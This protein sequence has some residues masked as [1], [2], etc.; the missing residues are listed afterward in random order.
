MP[1]LR[2]DESLSGWV[3]QLVDLYCGSDRRF[4]AWMGISRPPADGDRPERLHLLALSEHTG[5]PKTRL[6][7]MALGDI[8]AAPKIANNLGLTVAPWRLG[9]FELFDGSRRF[10]PVCLASGEA[11]WPLSWRMG[12]PVCL[13]HGVWL[14]R[15]CGRCGQ[16]MPRAGVTPPRSCKRCATPYRANFSTKIDPDALVLCR[17]IDVRIHRILAEDDGVRRRQIAHCVDWRSLGRWMAQSAKQIGGQPSQ[18]MWRAA[19]ETAA[20]G[21][22]EA[23]GILADEVSIETTTPLASMAEQPGVESAR[24]PIAVKPIRPE[25]SIRQCR[26]PSILEGLKARVAAALHEARDELEAAGLSPEPTRLRKRAD[27]ILRRTHVQV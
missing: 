17:A 19:F 4:W 26:S 23:G 18:E 14:E 10:C 7:T 11:L 2:Q 1:E 3:R 12:G 8:G 13:T 16:A 15:A 22:T 21:A 20:I 6:E 24:I 5:V 9:P 25:H 27:L